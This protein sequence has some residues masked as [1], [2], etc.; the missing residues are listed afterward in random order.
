MQ[1]KLYLF[2]TLASSIAITSCSKMGALSSDN[3]SVN[4]SPLETVGGKVSATINGRFPEKYMKKKAIVT[5][6]P[7]IRYAGGA[8]STSGATFQGEKVEDNNQSI[9]YRVGGNYTMKANFTYI[10][11]MM[12]SELYL[13]FNA[14]VGKK[15]ISIPAVKVANGVLST[16]ELLK[17]TLASASPA[18]APDAYEHIIKQKQD[19][20]IKFLIQQANIRTSELKTTSIKDFIKTLKDINADQER[21]ALANIE[22]SAYAS[23]DGGMK[24]NEKLAAQRE[25]T[26]AKY[27]AQQLKKEKIETDV[28]TKYTAEDWDGFQELVSQ[29]NIQDKDVIIRVLSMYKNPEEREKQIRNISAA[30]REL[31]NEILPQ[32]RRARLSINYELIGRS[33]DEIQAQIKSDASKLSVEEMLYAATLTEDA[34]EQESI[35]KK[36]AELYPNDYRAYNNLASISYANGKTSDAESYLSKATAL[37]SNA[38]ETN[39]NKA[40][41]SLTKGNV[42]EAEAFL[43]KGSGTNATAEALGNLYIAQG[44]YAQAASTMKAVKSNS[45]ALAQLLN[46]DY[47]SAEQTLS[48][49]TSAD[50]TTSYL[51]AIVA[52]RTGNKTAALSNLKDAIRQ[53]SSYAGYAA[54]D[55]EFSSIAG[56]ES[57]KALI[58]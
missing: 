7:E 38:A 17:R 14:K 26:S 2:L 39:V 9:S 13:T 48:S 1:N 31:A 52:A 44:N 4:P 33:D 16:S 28:D 50:A 20:N 34:N 18:I 25:K 19:A 10:P 5:V 37:N 12:Q 57:F 53:D 22:V 27:V 23:P 51:K 49:V 40:L 11:D 30:Y 36:T 58:K 3:F 56:D 55:L 29:S 32:L 24:L 41:L 35:Y 45:A 6:T 42:S 43:S 21:K 15:T 8:T 46:K 54:K 47:N